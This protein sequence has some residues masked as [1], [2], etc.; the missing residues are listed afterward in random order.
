MAYLQKHKSAILQLTDNAETLAEVIQKQT[1][2][3]VLCHGDIHAGN[4]LIAKNGAL[5]I[6]DWDQPI[7]APKE[8]DLM[9][10]GGG[11]GNVWNNKGEVELFYTGYGETEVNQTLIDY[12]R[13]E[14]IVQDVAEFYQL[15]TSGNI[16]YKDKL[17]SYN[18]FIA[19]F[20]PNGVVNIA[21]RNFALL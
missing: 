15:L 21:L 18:H 8:R 19:M 13:C 20:E 16:G 14:R 5:Y 4:V 7:M 12:Y 6:V 2:N 10:I 17:T 11:V 9:F 1:A 3:F